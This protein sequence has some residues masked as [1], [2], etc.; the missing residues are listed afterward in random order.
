MSS[1]VQLEVRDVEVRSW[2]ECT[3]IKVFADAWDEPV[4][5]YPFLNEQ[6][7]PPRLDPLAP[8]RER[9]ADALRTLEASYQD[10]LRTVFDLDEQ[11]TVRLHADEYNREVIADLLGRYGLTLD[12]VELTKIDNLIGSFYDLRLDE[13]FQLFVDWADIVEEREPEGAAST[14]LWLENSNPDRAC[15]YLMTT[16]GLS[17]H[18]QASEEQRV[19]AYQAL[20]A[21]VDVPLA[22]F[23]LGAL[24]RWVYYH[25]S[26]FPDCEP[27]ELAAVEEIRALLANR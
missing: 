24:L 15:H 20:Y 14:D 23:S 5:H 1:P 19:A 12:D 3:E 25:R 4:E 17:S 7:L 26:E 2:P 22:D 13:L 10:R 8:Y 16:A 21:E 9:A 27:F 11:A 18:S 6:P